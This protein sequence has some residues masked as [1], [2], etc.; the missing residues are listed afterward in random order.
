MLAYVFLH[1]SEQVM[2][3]HIGPEEKAL[4]IEDRQIIDQR[5]DDLEERRRE[6]QGGICGGGR[7]V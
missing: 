6:W 7:R 1:L 2:K 5:F 4:L 3:S